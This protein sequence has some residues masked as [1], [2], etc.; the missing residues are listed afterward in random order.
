MIFAWFTNN[1][2][3][4]RRKICILSEGRFCDL[5]ITYSGLRRI[6]HFCFHLFRSLHCF[7]SIALFLISFLIRFS[8]FNSDLHP[9]LMKIKA[10]SSLLYSWCCHG[11]VNYYYYRV[12][13]SSFRMCPS[14]EIEF[15]ST[16]PFFSFF[17]HHLSTLHSAS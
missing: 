8:H 14:F 16:A 11:V 9:I 10:I 4:S 17:Y 3:S 13:I 2:L 1:W 6:S 12:S 5:Y 7:S 15:I